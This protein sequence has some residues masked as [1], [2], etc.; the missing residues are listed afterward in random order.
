MNN[1]VE[2]R[3][4][5]EKRNL[6]SITAP[7][8]LEM[9]LRNALDSAPPKRIKRKSSPLWKIAAVIILVIVVSGN[10][11]NAFAYY[12][13]KLFGFDEVLEGTL[14]QLNEQGMGQSIDKKTTL[15]D[16]TELTINGIMADA[17]Q[18]IV[19]YTLNNPKGLEETGDHFSPSKIE[20]FLTNSNIRSGVSLINDEHTEIKG[21]MTFDSVSPFSKK[22][23]LHYWGPPQKGQMSEGSITFSYNPNQAMVTQIKQSI[24]KKVKADKGS[25]TFKSITATPTMTVIK[26]SMNVENFDR[27]RLGLEGIQLIANGKPVEIL[28]SSNKTSLGGRSFDIRYDTLPKELHSLQ[29]VVKEFVG[30]QKLEEKYPLNADSN[31]PILLGDKELWIKDVT[32]TAQGIEITIATDEDV[33]LDGV[34]IENANENT[35]LKTTINQKESEQTNGKLMK[36]RTLLFDTQT[37]PES[38]LIEGI[39]YMKEYNKVIEIPVD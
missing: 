14:Q 18:F 9:R 6:E 24:N 11:Y 13:K 38:I 19:Y 34:S 17:N 5:D 31:E 2:Q 12:G 29:L 25:I 4:V 37:K 36:E 8:G 16:G 26:G 7:E 1:N 39:H 30:Y 27:I 22:L 32:K 3:L 33:M 20:G 28:G 35:A 21:T 23:T 15:A 10:S